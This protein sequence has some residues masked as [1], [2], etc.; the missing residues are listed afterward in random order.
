MERDPNW[1]FIREDL[2]ECMK[3]GESWEE[4][5]FYLEEYSNTRACE[6]IGLKSLNS[7]SLFPGF[8]DPEVVT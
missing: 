7:S 2:A 8:S 4:T 1:H 5:A 3:L 6:V